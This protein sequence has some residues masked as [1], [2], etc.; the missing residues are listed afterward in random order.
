M[1]KPLT[2]E[3]ME[4]RVMALRALHESYEAKDSKRELATAKARIASLEARNT[5]LVE[6][7]EDILKS[8]HGSDSHWIALEALRADRK[9][10]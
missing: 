6:A 8:S 10:P 7:L 4:Q 2:P 1:S 9:K 5:R 3:E